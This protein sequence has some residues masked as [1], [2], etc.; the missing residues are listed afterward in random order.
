MSKPRTK[1][2]N[3]KN[4]LKAVKED[5]VQARQM[6]EDLISGKLRD[7]SGDIFETLIDNPSLPFDQAEQLAT[8]CLN[9]PSPEDDISEEGDS[10]EPAVCVES[11]V[12]VL[13][14][15]EDATD[16]AL[17]KWLGLG[18]VDSE[19]LVHLIGHPNLSHATLEKCF[20]QIDM[21]MVVDVASEGRVPEAKQKE[22]ATSK[23]PVV[24]AIAAASTKDREKLKALASDP[25]GRVRFGAVYNPMLP[26]S[27]LVDSAL[28]DNDYLVVSTATR[29]INDP[30]ILRQ[31]AARIW[32]N[33]P[34]QLKVTQALLQNRS[35]SQ[36]TRTKVRSAWDRVE[37]A[38]KAE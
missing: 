18:V 4:Y 22:F 21:Q 14:R 1:D 31:I 20:R 37:A 27:V 30:A 6:F 23:F 9:R 24:R 19:Y 29:K 10:D 35:T 17:A 34:E 13:C 2:E 25:E 28:N 12:F 36:N 32:K 26:A 16:D 3:Q 5:P 15:R 33:P 8:H 11:I 7:S 38:L